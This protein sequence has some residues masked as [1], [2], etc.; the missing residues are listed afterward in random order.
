MN[1]R[2]VEHRGGG[3]DEVSRAPDACVAGVDKALGGDEIDI[4]G[5]DAFDSGEDAD[6][7]TGGEATEIGLDIGAGGIDGHPGGGSG[8]DRLGGGAGGDIA[9]GRPDEDIATAESEDAGL[10]DID[11]LIGEKGDGATVFGDDAWRGEGVAKDIGGEGEATLRNAER[12]GAAGAR[13]DIAGAGKDHPWGGGLAEERGDGGEA[14]IIVARGGEGAAGIAE[15]GVEI[16]QADDGFLFVGESGG[17]ASGLDFF[18]IGRVGGGR[19]FEGGEVESALAEALGGASAIGT[20]HAGED[21]EISPGKGKEGVAE[22]ADAGDSQAR[23]VGEVGTCAE[24]EIVA[25]EDFEDAGTT[26]LEVARE[27]AG[28]EASDRG[29]F[30]IADDIAE[31]EVIGEGTDR[32]VF[33]IGNDVVSRGDDR[34]IGGADILDVERDIGDVI[35]G[36]DLGGL[37][38]EEGESRDVSALGIDAD[39]FG[40]LRVENR[41]SVEGA[42]SFNAGGESR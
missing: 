10:T 26:D 34:D 19:G 41:G 14:G 1:I 20:H 7:A 39:G 25:G 33:V 13:A 16:F 42:F 9:N 6:A 40:G 32:G 23:A 29:D 24:I 28:G 37:W 30:G 36:E 5:F 12:D 15:F 38:G 27:D 22:I 17:S 31:G 11:I 4:A 2:G 3:D 35:G 21:D 18:E 8:D